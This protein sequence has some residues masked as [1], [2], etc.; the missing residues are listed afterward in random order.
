MFLVRNLIRTTTRTSLLPIKPLLKTHIPLLSLPYLQQQNISSSQTSSN[1]ISAQYQQALTLISQKNFK[2]GVSHLDQVIQS[3]ASQPDHSKLSQQELNLLIQAQYHLGKLYTRFGNIPPATKL[4]TD[5]LDIIKRSGA[6]QNLIS[7][8]VYNAFGSLRLQQREHDEAKAYIEKAREILK[9]LDK[10]DS[11]VKAEYAQNS[12]L[13]SALYDESGFLDEALGLLE[14]IIKDLKEEEKT[15]QGDVDLPLVYLSVGDIYLTTKRD[16][17]QALKYWKEG[18]ELL[19]ARKEENTKLGHHYLQT[20]TQILI[21]KRI[22]REAQGYAEKALEAAKKIFPEKHPKIAD[23]YL[24]T[25]AVNFH[26]REYDKALEGYYKAAEIFTSHGGKYNDQIISTN[27]AMIEV[28]GLKEGFQEAKFLFGKT[29]ELALK[30]YGA[31]DSRIAD[32]YY[33]WAEQLRFKLKDC[34]EARNYFKKALDIYTKNKETDQS[35]YVAIYSNLG[36]SY[37][38]KGSF[39]LANA[40]EALKYLHEC[41]NRAEKVGESVLK[42]HALACK[43]LGV[44][45]SKQKNYPESIKYFEKGIALNEKTGDYSNIDVD[46]ANLGSAYKENVNLEKAI[47]AYKKALELGSYKFGKENERVQ[48]HLKELVSLLEGRGKGEEEI[49]EFKKNYEWKK[50]LFK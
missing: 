43:Y 19:Q 33:F 25:A 46:Y 41:V 29:I 39:E 45:Y 22:Y 5:A 2:E 1:D 4:L 12:Y 24:M 21:T 34:T 3:F 16:I 35:I 6:P 37:F 31:N 13:L 15:F 42:P 23:A 14:G 36:S 11:Q 20:V 9:G 50:P 10:R 49:K 47:E 32:Y 28:F 44:I 18:L 38:D 8:S 30:N 26:I 7:A 17:E 40:E 48:D 27:L